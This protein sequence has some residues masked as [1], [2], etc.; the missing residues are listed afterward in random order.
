MIRILAASAA[1]GADAVF[2]LAAHR[3]GKLN[4]HRQPRGPGLRH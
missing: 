3:L 1:P 2:Y 4:R